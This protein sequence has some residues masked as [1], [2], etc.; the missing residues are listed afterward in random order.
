MKTQHIGG[1]NNHQ[2]KMK[3]AVDIL[4]TAMVR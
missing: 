1:K 4:Y 2:K 3:K